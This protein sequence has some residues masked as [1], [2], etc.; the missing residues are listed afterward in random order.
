MKKKI[1]VAILLIST[2]FTV[3]A[4]RLIAQVRI[5]GK[6]VKNIV[7][8]GKAVRYVDREIA[9]K[10]RSAASVADATALL[11]SVGGVKMQDFDELGWA[12]IELPENAKPLDVLATLD[13]SASIEIAEPN[14]A[15]EVFLTPND[16]YYNGSGGATYP[17]QWGLNNVGQSPP[18][19]TNDADIDAPEAWDLTTGSSNVVLAILDTGI[20]MLNGALSHP[21]LDD[22][23][24]IILGPDY[25][26]ANQLNGVKDEFGHGTHV[27]G[28]AGAESNNGVGIAGVAWN[29]KLLIIQTFDAYG[30]G[31]ST[32][33]YN[34]IK[35]AVDYQINNPGTR[36]VINLSGGGSASQMLLDGVIYAKNNNVL[37]V[38]AAGNSGTA[39]P[40]SFPAAYSYTYS[41]VI[42][43][44]ST[45]HQDGVS[46]FSSRGCE[47]S[48]S[49][50]GGTGSIAD[51]SV[52][53]WNTTS[54]MGQNI[55]S[56]TPNYTFNLQ[57]DPKSLNDPFSTDITNNYGY[58]A[59]TSMATP[60][61][62]GAAALLLSKNLSLTPGEIKGILQASAD[63][64]GPAGRD[65]D[66]G[67]GR[68]SIYKA[69]RTFVAPV[70]GN[71]NMSSLPNDTYNKSKSAVWPL[72]ISNATR[73]NTA[74]A[75]YDVAS[76]LQFGEG[77]WI[78]FSANQDVTYQGSPIFATSMNVSK[79]AATDWN[80]I[81]S[82]SKPYATAAIIQNP[83]SNNLSEFFK[84]SLSG[85][86]VPTDVI[87]PG[88][89]IWVKV[90][91]SG[92]FLF[93]PQ[94]DACNLISPTNNSQG[95]NLSPTLSWS[96]VPGAINYQLQ[97]CNNQGFQTGLV[98]NDYSTQQPAPPATVV[99]RQIGPIP[100][101]TTYYWR[102]MAFNAYGG[103]SWSCAWNFRVQVDVIDE[104]PPPCGGVSSL[105]VLDQ[106]TVTNSNGQKQSLYLANGGKNLS[107]D[108][109]KSQVLPPDPVSGVFG[110]RFASGKF[111]ERIAPDGSIKRV[112]IKFKDASFPLTLSWNLHQEN[113]I[114]YW[115]IKPGTGNE[116]IPITNEGSY[117]FT[118]VSGDLV[119]MDVL[120]SVPPPCNP[121][122]SYWT[123][124][125]KEELIS[126][127]REY[128][129]NQNYPNPF[130]PAT[131]IKY[132]L[133]EDTH[134][135]LVIY[136]VIGRV[137][138]TLVDE[139]QSA[140]YRSVRFDA[141]SAAGGLP[142]GVY[143]YRLSAGSFTQT[144]TMMLLK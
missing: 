72:S 143:Y 31:T 22:P 43:V 38:A 79:T 46:A 106:F 4:D 96:V 14:G 36:V 137:V 27:A 54:N 114:Q 65:N 124:D 18:S 59:G 61:V 121:A 132:A 85:G 140:G 8:K 3:L 71:W 73:W 144:R 102:V 69:L 68:I 87:E 16:P 116:R 5:H 11:N 139:P 105:L 104:T 42:A 25:V 76:T 126:I 127:P 74:T 122:N 110:A 77:Y 10:R 91:Q 92:Q 115:L 7:W 2:A 21:D 64:F 19:G 125:A 118:S 37:I 52:Y 97:V 51:G 12:L 35:Y 112:P 86:Y 83:S 47:V 28:I 84:Y 1:F 81:G 93:Q 119:F 33:I 128:H 67:Y 78:K 111:I 136:D 113:G 20:P 26:D 57:I 45:T 32:T 13:N 117:T 133:S 62:S 17:Y 142:S 88:M 138:A 53:R 6:E 56:T 70:V 94:P 50:P 129:M 90:A 123:R 82:V 109:M 100:N 141:G 24:K 49:A 103:S 66:Y 108:L 9:V 29:S 23:N 55:Y 99:S 39:A 95:Q 41:N 101:H 58:L 15:T 98:V 130:N 131:D 48:V 135:K 134:V 107:Q 60:Y 75:S 44:G 120:V 34:G 63:D 30:S 80:L 89:G 40:V